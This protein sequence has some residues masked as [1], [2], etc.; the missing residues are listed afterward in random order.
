MLEK[1]GAHDHRCGEMGRRRWII[2]T[3]SASDLIP[4]DVQMPVLGGLEATQ[5]IRTRRSPPQLGQQVALAIPPIIAM[6][7]H[8]MQSDRDRCLM[9]G[10]DDYIAKPIKP[11]ELPRGDRTHDGRGGDLCRRR[12]SGTG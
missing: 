1:V 12:G 11:V 10:M 6:T 8:A 7:A 4:M 5:A 3:R 9:A 2:S